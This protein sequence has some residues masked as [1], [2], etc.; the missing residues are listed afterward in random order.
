MVHQHIE[1]FFHVSIHS[2]EH[3]LGTSLVVPW[4]K[5]SVP[6][7]SGLSSIPGQGTI[8]LIPQLKTPRAEAKIRGP[9]CCNEDPIQP[10]K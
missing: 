4:L 6:N 5:L 2:R 7:V 8:S 9:T 3:L 1:S 10:N